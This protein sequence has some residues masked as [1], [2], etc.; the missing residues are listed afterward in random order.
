MFARG[1]RERERVD[2]KNG[3]VVITKLIVPLLRSMG[4][5]VRM[6]HRNFNAGDLR[7]RRRRRVR[8]LTKPIGA[9]ID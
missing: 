1:E 9:V 4:Y 7:L 8:A 6:L 2:G 3:F 5:V